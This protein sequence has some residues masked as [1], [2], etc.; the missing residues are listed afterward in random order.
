MIAVDLFAGAGGF[1]EGARLA[2]V[3]VVYAANH[4]RIAVDAH[5][6]NHPT[7]QHACQDLLACRWDEVPAHDLL[8]A[9]PA[10]T[11]FTRAR[12]KDSPRW[13][14]AR[15]T[16]WAVIS[17]AEYHRPRVVVCENVVEMRDM[18]ALWPS[19]RDALERLGYAVG[20]H[21]IDAADCGVPQHRRRLF[22]VA[23]RSRW[24]LQLGKPQERHVPIHTVVDFGAGEWTPIERP[25][26]AEK[27]L[28]R[29]RNGRAEFGDRFLIPY[30]GSETGGRSLHRPIG[31]LTTRDRYGVVDGD[32]MR[33]L[34]VDEA[35]AA[36][37][38]PSGYVL[39]ERHKDAI[40]ALG[41]AVAPPA[42]DWVLRLVKE[43]A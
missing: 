23:T 18:W 39:P 34:T 9:S 30:F 12:G 17:C 14:A 20:E 29:V 1:T 40:A 19:W 8:L 37:G 36:M 16:P 32:R 15:S 5:A 41:N 25:S 4:W 3:R 33:M 11:G 10:C 13:D 22:I 42:A 28:R 31:T 21:I 6:A 35:R 7:A 43:A 26:R 27:T 38:F 24:P 2:G